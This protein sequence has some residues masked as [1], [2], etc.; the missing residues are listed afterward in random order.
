MSPV[1]ASERLWDAWLVSWIIAAVWSR[2]TVAREGA[3]RQLA[4]WAPTVIGF[5]LLTAGSRWPAPG[6]LGRPLWIVGP[7]LGWA[8]AAACAAGLAFTWW[9]RLALGPLWSGSI[10]FKEGH[11]VV[12][13]GPYALVRHPIYTGLILAAFA[14]A[15]QIGMAANL[16]GAVVIAAGFWR[17]AELEER[18]LSEQLGEAAYGAYRARTPM[19]IPFWPR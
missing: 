11:D 6:P 9:A 18:F 8:L 17:K 1:V 2:R 16:A 19:L 7:A 3:L 10:T 15:A 12:R 13:S 5:L 14:L 4:H